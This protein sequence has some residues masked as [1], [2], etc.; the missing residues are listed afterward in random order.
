MI[1]YGLTQE[2]NAKIETYK[3]AIQYIDKNDGF[4]IRLGQKRINEF[5]F[6]GFFDYGSSSFKSDFLDIFLIL[7]SKV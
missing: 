1:I 7:S 2:E 4:T 5:K 6:K 3:K